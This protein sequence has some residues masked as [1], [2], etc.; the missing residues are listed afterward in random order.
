MH[1]ARARNYTF[2]GA[3]VGIIVYMDERLADVDVLSVGM[4][5]QSLCLLFAEQGVGTCVQA[6]IAGYGE[7]VKEVLG[8]EKGMRVLVG[9]A[10]G[11][12][13]GGKGVNGVR[14]GREGWEG[15]VEFRD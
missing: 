8:L 15:S 3:P 4:Y 11:Y 1:K 12:E 14:V 2:F 7:I 13:D 9:V 10:V 5:V 6:S